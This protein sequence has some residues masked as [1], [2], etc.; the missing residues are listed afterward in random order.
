MN[1]QD[2]SLARKPRPIF[3]SSTFRDMRAEREKIVQ[4]RFLGWRVSFNG[5][6]S[7]RKQLRETPVAILRTNPSMVNISTAQ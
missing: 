6:L 2:Q 4:A 7:P 3:I 5:S 1:G